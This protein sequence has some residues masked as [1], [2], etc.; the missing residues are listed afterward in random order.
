M[1]PIKSWFAHFPSQN[2]MDKGGIKLKLKL[3]STPEPPADMDAEN[4]PLLS[5]EEEVC[6]RFIQVATV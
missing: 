5:D 4:N 2:M 6:H 1:Y 3:S